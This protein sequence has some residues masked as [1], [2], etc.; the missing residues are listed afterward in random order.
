VIQSAP[1]RHFKYDF[2]IEMDI[3]EAIQLRVAEDE[4][5]ILRLERIKLNLEKDREAELDMEK[6]RKMI[7]EMKIRE[8]EEEKKAREDE[9][10][11][12]EKLMIEEK[13]NALTAK[14]RNMVEEF[15]AITGCTDLD[16]RIDFLI[17]CKWDLS[18]AAQNYF[19]VDGSLEKLKETR[20]AVVVAPVVV[21]AK[22]VIT[23]VYPDK[24]SDVYN[25][26]PED[27]MWAV[28]ER[29]SQHS[30]K[31]ANKAFMLGTKDKAFIDREMDG[32][33]EDAGMV[34]RGEIHIKTFN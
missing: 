22:A 14:Q 7:E 25:F 12:L 29:L 2:T 19:E 13:L 16:T 32:T 34:P 1:S 18:N 3:L 17:F 11:L 33:L 27:T 30:G 9:K 10:I 28:Y 20:P 24:K 21:K 5:K 31:W 6:T 15:E 8:E 4:S 23:V 26:E